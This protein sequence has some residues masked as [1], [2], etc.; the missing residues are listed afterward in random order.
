MEF[1]RPEYWSGYPFHSPGELP[2]P[3]IEPR[4]PT[5]RTTVVYFFSILTSFKKSVLFGFNFLKTF[6]FLIRKFLKCIG[7]GIL[8]LTLLFYLSLSFDNFWCLP[9][10]L[11]LSSPLILCY[12]PLLLSLFP[13]PCVSVCLCLTLCLSVF[14]CWN[15]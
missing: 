7:E 4:S 8:L 13:S 10:L 9:V 5:L 3:G 15:I 6:F 11:H 2:N 14:Q 1:S 12:L